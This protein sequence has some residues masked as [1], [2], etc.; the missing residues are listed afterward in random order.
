MFDLAD[1]FP[2]LVDDE[3]E[4]LKQLVAHP[5][6]KDAEKHLRVQPRDAAPAA[7]SN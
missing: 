1:R 7:G 6:I 3:F 4:L 5:A 2:L